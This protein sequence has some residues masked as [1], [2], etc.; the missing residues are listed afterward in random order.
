MLGLA[1]SAWNWNLGNAHFTQTQGP[2]LRLCKGLFAANLI[3][4][5]G[6]AS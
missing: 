3:P 1:C 6:S 2:V 5:K 4:G